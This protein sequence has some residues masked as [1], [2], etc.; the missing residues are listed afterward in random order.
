MYLVHYIFPMTLPLL[1]H[2]LTMIPTM[3]KF[4]IVAISTVIF[5]Y[6]INR[7]VMKPFPK[8]MTIGVIAVSVLL[9][10]IY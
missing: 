5:S 6:L 1:L 3:G 8:L 2:N 7:F 4:G 9:S 10:I